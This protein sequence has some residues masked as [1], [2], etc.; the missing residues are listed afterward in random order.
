MK[1]PVPMNPPSAN[2]RI[3]ASSA[4]AVTSITLSNGTLLLFSFCG[5]TPTWYALMRSPQMAT[6][7]TPRTPSNRARI[8]QYAVIDMSSSDIVFD[9]SPI[10]MTRLVAESGCIMMGGAAQVG[11]VFCTVAIRSW[12]S[13]RACIVSVPRLKISSR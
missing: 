4:W 13:C 10:F 8:F 6:F 2:F 12:T 1:P 5:S 9:D 3:P 7:A 11:S